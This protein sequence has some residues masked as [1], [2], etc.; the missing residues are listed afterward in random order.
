[1]SPS[2]APDNLA[3]RTTTDSPPDGGGNRTSEKVYMTVEKRGR[4][5]NKESNRR[6]PH[7][8]PQS[9]KEEKTLRSSGSTVNCDFVS[10]ASAGRK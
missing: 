1:M 4:G 10:A 6:G 3:A 2:F 9:R 8:K 5:E 7:A